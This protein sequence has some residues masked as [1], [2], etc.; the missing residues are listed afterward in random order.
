MFP[1]YK[2]WKKVGN[3]IEEGVIGIGEEEDNEVDN[4]EVNKVVEAI[5]TNPQ[6]RKQKPESVLGV[7]PRRTWLKV[8]HKGSMPF[9]QRNVS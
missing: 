2:S 6:N 4:Q 8:V 3:N 5:T 9:V 7:G 1:N